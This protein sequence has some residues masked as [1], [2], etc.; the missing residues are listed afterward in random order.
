MR[1][2]TPAPAVSSI[3]PDRRPVRML[4]FTAWSFPALTAMLFAG[5]TGLWLHRSRDLPGVTG[6]VAL[7]ACIALW[8][9]GQFVGSL[10]TSLSLKLLAARLET[11]GM[12][13]APAAWFV[14]AV[15]YARRRYMVHRVT[16]AVIGIVPLATTALAWTSGFHA[17]LW[18][19]I[20]LAPG[21]GFVGMEIEHGLWFQV[22]L[23]YAIA[24]LTAG[25]VILAFELSGAARNRRV[26]G[27]VV[28]TPA[29]VAALQV[30]HL[31]PWNPMPPVDATPLGFALGALL[32]A[33][34][35]LTRGAMDISP[36]LR[37]EVVEKLT[38]GVVVVDRAGRV[39]DF[40]AAAQS[41][42][43]P[44]H[45]EIIGRRINE[46]FPHYI[47]ADLSA[48]RSESAEVSL[49]TRTYHVRATRLDAL[50]KASP[51]T[52]LVFRDITE[53]LAAEN[54]LR[55]VKHDLER[56]A[57]TDSLTG[58][59]NRRFFMQRL[60]EET[61]RVKRHGGE[62]SVVLFDLD[63]FKRVNDTHGHD[64]GDRVLMAVADVAREIVRTSDVAG[65]L[66]G[67]EFGL[68]LPETDGHG[69]LRL[70][71]RLR[72]AVEALRIGGNGEPSVT[73]TTSVGVATIRESAHEP[74]QVL[75]RADQALY[76]AKRAGRNTVR[77]AA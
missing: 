63:L 62:L 53:R 55:R 68:L 46:L 31:S 65:R 26:F 45:A 50:V 24:M 77:A 71:E 42:L 3:G 5:F 28:L 37:R 61:A 32:V 22:Q 19:G 51:R 4:Q 16:L 9:F 2:A 23:A 59:H 70:A 47:I 75:S 33:Y 43:L 15:T 56:L 64:M 20:R 36:L 11:P 25:T 69:A 58:L 52:V 6:L 34:G 60:A 14:F 17:L 27:A 57:H 39:V 40:N 54:E 13:F 35:V 74:G 8:A 29:I 76:A 7:C 12:A 38:D 66:G 72:G 44:H 48:G 10:T 41:A 49:E 67:E 21:D 30:L 18:S 1:T 73:I